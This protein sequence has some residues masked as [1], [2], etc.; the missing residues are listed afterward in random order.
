MKKSERAALLLDHH[1]DTFQNILCQWKLR[2]RL[3]IFVLL[4]LAI[5]AFDTSSP[6]AIA[7]L[8]NNYLTKAVGN[9]QNQSPV[10]DFKVIGAAIWFLLLSLVIGYYQRSIVVDR[11]YQYIA[12]LE[13]QICEEMGGDFI[14]REGKAYLSKTGAYIE[15]E[16]A[17]RPLFVRA[18]GPLYT[19]FFPLVLTVFV[20]FK[21]ITED[22]PAPREFTDYVNLLIGLMIIAY[23]IFYVIWVHWRK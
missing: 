2:N 11:Q 3:F 17:Q 14:T 4:L 9:A 23:N 22:L 19:I 1:K 20:V 16:E 18:V 10:F 15:G 6:G 21:L 7:G 12:K 8:L 5:I 13:E